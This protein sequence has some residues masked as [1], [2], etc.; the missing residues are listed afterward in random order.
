[1]GIA[2]PVWNPVPLSHYTGIRDWG[3]VT[4][5]TYEYSAKLTYIP[6]IHMN[7]QRSWMTLILV[8]SITILLVV[9]YN[10]KHTQERL[11]Q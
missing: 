8:A 10:K 11:L 6:M 9:M 5:L 4:P 2:H 1:M 3:H 7:P